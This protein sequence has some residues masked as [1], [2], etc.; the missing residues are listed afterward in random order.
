MERC[1]VCAN[2]SVKRLANA[3]IDNVVNTSD[4]DILQEVL[5]DSGN[6]DNE[7]NIMKSIIKGVKDIEQLPSNGGESCHVGQSPNLKICCLTLSMR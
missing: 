6:S 1:R 3:I 4:E 2:K 5:E 7:S